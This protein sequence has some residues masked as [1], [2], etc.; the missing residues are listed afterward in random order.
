VQQN[1]IRILIVEDHPAMRL[2]L[3]SILETEPDIKV[4]ADTGDP[5]QILDLA[6]EHIPD[7][8]LLDLEIPGTNHLTANVERLAKVETY[9]VVVLT[10]HDE[11]KFIKQA[12]MAGAVDVLSKSMNMDEIAERIRAA[13]RGE[14]RTAQALA[15]KEIVDYKPLTPREIEIVRLIGEGLTNK[16]IGNKL[17]CSDRTV[18]THVRNM[19]QKMGVANRAGIVSEAIKRG[20]LKDL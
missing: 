16:A 9:Q 20:E 7:V 4:V 8:V 15:S 2:G 1:I 13:M 18:S 17:H 19:M 10:A 3:K 6:A 11:S 14:T 12:L 5:T